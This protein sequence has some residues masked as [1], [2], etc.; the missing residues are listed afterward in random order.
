[1]GMC[2]DEFGKFGFEV[3]R[4]S[5]RLICGTDQDYA[6]IE[7]DTDELSDLEAAIDDLKR[8]LQETR[9]NDEQ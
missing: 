5:T 2:L 8:Y 4:R 6:T 9:A 7:F 1:M 3:R